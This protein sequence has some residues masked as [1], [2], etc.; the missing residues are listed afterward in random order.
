MH[1]ISTCSLHISSP[2]GE[3]AK[4]MDEDKTNNDVACFRSLCEIHKPN[5][6][7]SHYKWGEVDKPDLFDI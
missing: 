2:D 1:V 3:R 4:S 5:S 7:L 6:D